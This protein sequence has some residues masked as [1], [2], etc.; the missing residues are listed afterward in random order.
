[1]FCQG[2]NSYF[3]R[4]PLVLMHVGCLLA[5]TV[6]MLILARDQISPSETVQ[7]L[8]ERS[9]D[10]IEFPVLFKICITP[11]FDTSELHKAGYKSIWSYFTGQSRHDESVF[12]W[13]GH[14]ADGSILASV[15]GKVFF[16]LG[17]NS[18]WKYFRYP[19]EVTNA[20]KRYH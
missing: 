6:Q 1:M 14:G 9:L 4:N 2:T 15:E 17:M 7:H 20:S 13:A 18:W 12:G 10:S 8:E 3:K 11:A 5:F 19:K 16:A